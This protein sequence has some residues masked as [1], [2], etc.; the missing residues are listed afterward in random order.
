M[1]EETKTTEKA[2]KTSKKEVSLEAGTYVFT[3]NG[4]YK[5]MPEGE[6]YTIEADEAE[7]LVNKG[8]GTAKKVY[9]KPE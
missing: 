4:K 9:E 8:F 1:S 3:S 5:N 2:A 6:Q 7:I